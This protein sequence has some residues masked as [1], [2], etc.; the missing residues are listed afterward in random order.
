MH[1]YVLDTNVFIH[2]VFF[3]EVDWAREVGTGSMVCIVVT[4]TVLSELD[5]LKYFGQTA[6]IKDRAWKVLRKIAQLTENASLETEIPLRN[7]SYLLILSHAPKVNEFDG[8]DVGI[9]DDRIIASSL[10]LQISKADV[11][12]LTADYGIVPKAR[13]HGLR[14]KSLPDNLRLKDE[15]DQRDREL[16]RLQNEVNALKTREPHLEAV[17][18]NPEIE[19][20]AA[21]FT[22]EVVSTLDE[23]DVEQRVELAEE[24]YKF[25]VGSKGGLGIGD[26]FSRPRHMDDYLAD[27][28]R[29]L[30]QRQHYED[31]R[32][33][34]ATVSLMVLNTGSVVAEDVVVELFFPAPL[35]ICGTSDLPE[36]PEAPK[37]YN[38]YS[39]LRSNLDSLVIPTAG[40]PYSEP[41]ISAAAPQ[42]TYRMP[43]L[44]HNVSQKLPA[45][46]VTFLE[47]CVADTYEVIT[48]LHAGNQLTPTEAKLQL[49]IASASKKAPLVKINP[50]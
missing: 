5:K 22:L 9:P 36:L 48:R 28:R 31:V 44:V 50:E 16:V 26:I 34:A 38:N 49:T 19:G 21:H 46:A 47:D 27:F 23:Q 17:L 35:E 1:Y 4:T 8:L 33:R 14:A 12:L 45:F 41:V 15:P 18:F 39:L 30:L 6:R 37:I 40:L 25:Q 42:V 2:G 43:R 13:S 10:K 7:K 29:F 24:Y 3:D 32:G 11:S 20:L